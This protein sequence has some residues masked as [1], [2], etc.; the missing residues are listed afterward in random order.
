MKSYS[1]YGASNE[2]INNLMLMALQKVVFLPFAL[3]GILLTVENS[4]NPRKVSSLFYLSV[5]EVFSHKI[6]RRE[7]LI[8]REPA[9]VTKGNSQILFCDAHFGMCF[10]VFTI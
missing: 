2:D 8:V 9:G 1:V 3:A 7:S 10:I 6:G 5:A 4:F